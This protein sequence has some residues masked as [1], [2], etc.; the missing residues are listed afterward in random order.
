M[1]AQ[2]M[3][4]FHS[5]LISMAEEGYLQLLMAPTQ[6]RMKTQVALCRYRDILAQLRGWTQQKT[7]DHYEEL[8][9]ATDVW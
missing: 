9:S 3:K 4:A 5:S 2:Q 7:Q 8:A 1:D 6:V